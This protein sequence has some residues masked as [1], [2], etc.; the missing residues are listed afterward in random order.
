[1]AFIDPTNVVVDFLLTKLVDP[2]GRSES[3]TSV[4]P[5]P[6]DEYKVAKTAAISAK[7]NY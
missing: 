7:I 6:L 2:R 1:M 4:D 3:T 5:L